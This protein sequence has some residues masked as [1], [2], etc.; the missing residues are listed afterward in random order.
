MFVPTE[1]TP[2]CLIWEENFGNLAPIDMKILYLL[3]QILFYH[4]LKI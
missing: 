3:S 2:I 4:P 1:R